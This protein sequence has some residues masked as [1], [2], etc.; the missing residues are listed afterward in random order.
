MKI[1][2][3]P[4]NDDRR[5]V[6]LQTLRP[7]TNFVVTKSKNRTVYI[8]TQDYSNDSELRY[9]KC[10]GVTLTAGT[11]VGFDPNKLV[12]PILATCCV[13]EDF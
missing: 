2:Y 11:L 7:G 6:E 10:Y 12:L 1:E 9:D 8:K 3:R 5:W 13:E 4:C